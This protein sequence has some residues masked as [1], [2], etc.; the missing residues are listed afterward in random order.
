MNPIATIAAIRDLYAHGGIEVCTP[1]D[2]ESGASRA[3]TRLAARTVI[4]PNADLLIHV[5]P[6]AVDNRD[7]WQAHLR[8]VDERMRWLRRVRAALRYSPYLSLVWLSVWAGLILGP[9]VVNADL[10]LV[11]ERAV[12]AVLGFVPAAGLWCLRGA[13]F[14]GIRFWVNRELRG[15]HSRA[16]PTSATTPF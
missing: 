9:A 6:E 13:F 11:A 4:Q 3:R 1:L 12:L 14:F 16:V 2:G 5:T 15:L 8:S 7:V 10:E